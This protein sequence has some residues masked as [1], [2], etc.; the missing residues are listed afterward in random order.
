M[1]LIAPG[2]CRYC[3]CHGESCRTRD[4]D[5]CFFTNANQTVCSAE[6][7]QRA[8]AERLRAAKAARDAAK[9][10]SKYRGWGYG[11]IVADL[12]RKARKGGKGRAA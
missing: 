3:G 1:T 2:V 6:A 10:A 11:A 7:C 8:E 4:G 12:R 5:L 9:P